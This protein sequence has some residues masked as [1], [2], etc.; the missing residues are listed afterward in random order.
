MNRDALDKLD[1]ES[2]P[3]Y[4]EQMLA[5]AVIEVIG[6]RDD[7]TLTPQEFKA[8]MGRCKERYLSAGWSFPP[9]RRQMDKIESLSAFHAGRAKRED[10]VRRAVVLF[11]EAMLGI[12]KQREATRQRPKLKAKD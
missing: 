7:R 9:S 11:A 8:I 2:Y 10:R 3:A 12:K 4:P 5:Q 1:P 6:D